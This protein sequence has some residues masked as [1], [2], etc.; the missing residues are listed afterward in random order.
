MKLL[1]LTSIFLFFSCSNNV[2]VTETEYVRSQAFN[3]EEFKELQFAYNNYLDYG[4]NHNTAI[5]LKTY[6]NQPFLKDTIKFYAATRDSLGEI[7]RAK[8][9]IFYSKYPSNSL[10]INSDDF[11][12]RLSEN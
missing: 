11:K 10:K 7:L 6:K 9:D 8:G 3:S 1:S 2:M 12:K 4:K 5:A